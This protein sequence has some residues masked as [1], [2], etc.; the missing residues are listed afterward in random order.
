MAFQSTFISVA[1]STIDHNSSWIYLVDWILALILGLAFVFYFG[2]LVGFVCSLALKWIIWKKYEVRINVESLRISLLGGRILAKNLTITTVDQTI[3]VLQVNFTWR[4]WISKLTRV[5]EY[6][7]SEN[8][9]E[10]IQT[11]REENEKLLARFT[12][13]L[14]G[15]EIFMYN[16]TPAY[17]NMMDILKEHE[18]T[19]EG[20]EK[21]LLRNNRN[22]SDEEYH[23]NIQTNNSNSSSSKENMSNGDS[24]T[25]SASIPPKEGGNI[26]GNAASNKQFSLY[27]FLK[28]LPVH[29]RIKRGAI[30]LGNITTPSIL[31]ASYKMGN[32]IVDVSQAPCVLDNYRFFYNFNFER[33]QIS[34]K[35][36]ITYDK[37]KYSSPNDF[38]N[39]SPVGNR[40]KKQN[41]NNKKK[42]EQWYRF[43]QAVN[44]ISYLIK[45]PFSRNKKRTKGDDDTHFQQWKGL[46]RYLGDLAEGQDFLGYINTDE[47]YAKYSLILDSSCTRMSYYYD[48]PGITPLNSNLSKTEMKDP[49]FGVDMELSMATIHYGPWADRQRAPLQSMF[50]PT[51]ARDSKPNEEHNIPGKVRGYNGFNFLLTVKDQVIFRV[52]TREPSKHTETL[53]NQ[54]STNVHNQAGKVSRPFGW[55]ELNM[56]EGSN[57]NFFNS[58]VAS[59]DNGWNNELKAVFHSFEMRSS[60][61]HDIL[62][63]A[64]K[65]SIDCKVGFPLK[66][67]G[68]CDWIFDNIS[69]N[70]KLF[71]LREHTMLISDIFTDFASGPPLP[72]ELFRPFHYHINWKLNTY[73]LYLNVN[74]NNIINNPLDFSSNKYL[75]FQGD[76]LSCEVS[77]PLYGQFSKSTTIDYN[78]NTS[79]TKFILDTPQWHTANAFMKSNVIGK[80]SDFTING[81]YTYFS[82]VE[83]NTSNHVVIKVLGDFVT[84]KFY[85]FVVRY[86]FVIRENYL[87]DHMHF[88][89][90]EEYTNEL[91][92]SSQTMSQAEERSSQDLS[93]EPDSVASRRSHLNYWKMIK[94]VNDVD[95][96]FMFQVRHGLLLLPY[97][98]HDCSSHV[99]LRFDSFDIDIR[100]TNY[101]SDL[102]ADFSPISLT[103]VDGKG[104]DEIIFNIPKY[105]ELFLGENQDASID[106]LTIHTHRMFGL[107]PK[108]VTYYSKWD[109]ATEIINIDSDGFFILAIMTS[110]RS[111]AFGFKDLENGLNPEFPFIPNAGN[112]SFRCPH[113]LI[114]LKP[115]KHSEECSLFS[116]DLDSILLSFNDLANDRYSERLS[117]SIPLIIFK[118]VSKAEGE[119]K[120]LGFLETSLVADN[121]MQKEKSSEFKKLQQEH[122]RTNDAPYHR[123]PF[124]LD[125]YERDDVY[126][127][128]YGCIMTSL[129]LVDASYPLNKASHDEI[130]GDNHSVYAPSF[131]NRNSSGSFSLTWDDD[132]TT[133]GKM[134]PLTSYSIHEYSPD[135]EKDSKFKID[136]LIFDFGEIMAFFTP[137][138][139]FYMY[140]LARSFNDYS[141]TKLIDDLHVDV[142]QKL[143]LLISS[144]S[145]VDNIR[146][147][148]QEINLKVG[149]F[150]VSDPLEVF[151]TSPKVPNINLNITEPS[152]AISHTIKRDTN[153]RIMTKESE[154]V[155]AFHL[156]EAL[157][158]VSRPSEFTSPLSLGIKNIEFWQTI[159][160]GD[161]LVCSFDVENTDLVIDEPQFEWLFDYCMSI[162]DRIGPALSDFKRLSNANNKSVS[163]LVYKISTAGRDFHI[164]HD[165]GVLTKPASVLRSQND[166]IRFFDSWKVMTR[167]RHIFDHLPENWL[168][169][170]DQLFK[171]FEWEAPD[172]AYDEV[173]DIFSQ[174]RSWEV[175]DIRRSY[176]F[177]FIFS[178]RQEDK[179]ENH[180]DTDFKI[181]L[182]DINITLMGAENDADFIDFHELTTT[183]SHSLER[184]KDLTNMNLGIIESILHCS[185]LFNLESY[186]SKISPLALSLYSPLLRKMSLRS[187]NEQCENKVSKSESIQGS[188]N[189]SLEFISNVNES[190][191]RISFPYTSIELC[192]SLFSSSGQVFALKEI[193][194][195]IPF[196]LSVVA[197][198]FDFALSVNENKLASI[199]FES[200]GLEAANFGTLRNGV[201]IIDT[202]IGKCNFNLLDQNDTLCDSLKYMLDNDGEFLK[203]TF[204][205]Y[206]DSRKVSD[207]SDKV[208]EESRYLF[209]KIGSVSIEFHVN[210]LHWFIDIIHPLKLKGI[211]DDI[212]LSWHL[213]EGISLF[214]SF[215]Q[216]L[217][218][219]SSI[220]KTSIIEFE[221]SQILNSIKFSLID[222]KY[223]ISTSSSLGYTKVFIPKIIKS[224]EVV[225]ANLDLVESKIKRLNIVIKKDACKESSNSD[226]S[227]INLKKSFERFVLRSKFTNDYIG[228][229]TFVDTSKIAVELENFS[230]GIYNFENI[231]QNGNNI[232]SVVPLFGNLL[233][234]TTRVSII[235]RSV[236]VGLSN[237]LDVNLSVKVCNDNEMSKEMLSLQIESQYCRVCLS[238]QLIF[239]LGSIVDKLATAALK[240]FKI[241][242]NETNKKDLGSSK[243]SNLESWLFLFS[244]IHVLSYNFCIG[245]LF[246]ESHKDYPGIILGAE[247]F[248]AVV[249]DSLGKFTLIDAYLSVANGF[250]SSNFYSTASEKEN[251]N[252][253]SLPNMQLIYTIDGVEDHRNMRII[254]NGDELDVKFLSDSIVILEH[255]VASVS[256]VQKIF[257]Q[258]VK[259]NIVQNEPKTS[260]SKGD[261][262]QSFKSAFATIEIIATFAGSNVLLY[263][264]RDNDD[265]NPPSLFLHSPAVKIATMYKHQK[266][267]NKKHVIKSEILTSSSDNTLYSSCMPVIMDIAQG[268]K[269]MMRKTNLD[270]S[271]VAKKTTYESTKD[272]DFGDLLND[273]DIHIGVRIERQKLALSCEPTAKVATVVGIDGIYMQ[274]NTG[275]NEIPSITAAVQFDSISA[276]L[277]HIYSRE[278]SGSIGLERILLTSSVKMEKVL[279][280][281]C[282]GSFTDVEAYINVKQFQDLN[283]FK[284]IWFPKSK[285]ESHSDIGGHREGVL[286]TNKT[287]ELAANKNIS[288]RFKE[289]STT[290]ALPW[291]LTFMIFNVSLRMD[292]GQS[293]GNFKL[294]SDRIWV[295]SKKS[296][297]WTQEL[298]LGVNSIMLLAEGRLS[299]VLNINS[300][301]LHTAIT[302]KNNNQTTLDVPLILVSGGIES[303]QLKLSFDY[304]VFAIAN[305]Q[306]YSIDIFNK[307]NELNTSKDHLFVTTKFDNAEFYITS[308]AASNV[309]DIYNA[310][311]RM[312]Q[313]NRTSYKETLRDS[314]RGKSIGNAGFKRTAS[315]EI[316]ETVKKLET[317][318]EVIAGNLLIHVYPSSFS[319]SKVLVI[320]LDESIANFQQNEYSKGISNQ[321]DIQFNDL[322]VSLSIASIMLEDFIS[323]CSVNEFVGYARKAAGGTIFVFPSFKI[324]MRTFQ[325]YRSNLIEYLYQSSFGKSVDIRWNLGSII[326]IREMY[327][328]H[329]NAFASRTEYKKGNNQ[330]TSSVNIG[331][332]E[333]IFAKDRKL[334]SA[335]K[336]FNAED[337]TNE[338]DQAINDTLKKVSSDSKFSYS[339][340]APPIIEAPQLKELGN[341][342]PPLEWFGL[343][344]NKFPNATHQLGIVSLQKLI[345]E[346]ELQYSKILGKA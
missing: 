123:C 282:S 141:L 151:G 156:K 284:D 332:K 270:N 47:E 73:K 145:L 219:G 333:D 126:N 302:W 198:T 1:N 137:Q 80:S 51:L 247:R 225:A 249:E 161:N 155:T 202:S 289:V 339:P 61:N 34:M 341:A 164:D 323:R 221:N 110:L 296:T 250:R 172:D 78:I 338:I 303:L 220:N 14:D 75:S 133:F 179:I 35:P 183:Y 278:V 149:D 315:N 6:Y 106:G 36:N 308:L 40:N 331:F 215:V 340:L 89:T 228:F 45:K 314:S 63:M 43:N 181:H 300:I 120:L 97:Y 316:L 305:I 252:R 62:F 115:E 169:D 32:A 259:P 288:S 112:F 139:L 95:I 242:R 301:F 107:P 174:W 307:K 232:G 41:A 197:G 28:V 44:S 129:T 163:E 170:Q 321:L 193:S 153:D 13:L 70:G 118:I 266:N 158:S 200:F 269:K 173:L 238:P 119:S 231:I 114:N 117:A 69:D 258:R 150:E 93:D 298:K 319:D 306:K 337:P 205:D 285:S 243:K 84:L 281:L 287:S 8:N 253:A 37:F 90:F 92:N 330:L 255:T 233:I 87:G 81:S 157:L 72:Y 322:N 65:H 39:Y 9:S 2:R 310:I 121:I 4:Y 194:D 230:L 199:E 74:D 23:Q 38:P 111:F 162:V 286:Q 343:H 52:P 265:L 276:S 227:N 27:F 48:C 309:L 15:L 264:L 226:D 273:F 277:Q 91:A 152:L 304:H 134:A 103:Y 88:K 327:S 279:N 263:R 191:Q 176:F 94:S 55:L 18:K 128:A 56:K 177:N 146:F 53:R 222:E 124:V 214:E 207:A 125:E 274:I 291:F 185:I 248:F 325:K 299:G 245:W 136:N 313:E 7:F 180:H 101:Y 42:Y 59:R 192:S 201:K 334:S 175:D 131:D 159:D 311:I 79:F 3:S 20:D 19:A 186:K 262:I 346:V 96:L 182:N 336:S 140:K 295:V 60:V 160:S 54:N 268:I 261:Y 130:E 283:L 104:N 171:N 5:S 99:G 76:D 293:L 165:P 223:V 213:A 142:I 260:D 209:E 328:I 290:Y 297:D 344:R 189:I 211:V 342:T 67:N 85:G 236:P 127:D 280:I 49:E 196:S 100:F 251:L 144:P 33:F 24:K 143:K 68:K 244:A 148:T 178:K 218:F 57:I 166:H 292:F 71:F 216:K 229:S 50:F 239:K 257:S 22:D 102:Q 335:S 267:A 190:L 275:P 210:E 58:Y 345:H 195:M 109:F 234:P 208:S 31:V 212:H 206:S 11:T 113:A 237:V 203:E 187:N 235:D 66:W 256:K 324:S 116:I 326:F 184:F 168:N 122:I 240:I 83:I 135:Y 86:L 147:V 138:S 246:G 294:K 10:L 108:E 154:F 46:R 77:I 132:C 317:K 318:I 204:L 329:K 30:V 12:L 26:C 17:D 21:E 320:T 224:I 105:T 312:I 254:M 29:I 272:F 25:S 271:K 16:R 64:D 167:L 217:T 98:L 82:E 188:N 241:G